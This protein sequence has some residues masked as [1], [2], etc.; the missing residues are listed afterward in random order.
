MMRL[1]DEP[2]AEVLNWHFYVLDLMEQADQKDQTL[3]WE[4]LVSTP[5]KRLWMSSKLVSGVI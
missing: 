2:L 3:A 1:H 5:S 4:N